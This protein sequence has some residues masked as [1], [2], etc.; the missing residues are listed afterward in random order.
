MIPQCSIIHPETVLSMIHEWGSASPQRGVLLTCLSRRHLYARLKALKALQTDND[1]TLTVGRSYWRQMED[2]LREARP[3]LLAVTEQYMAHC[4][5][6]D[7]NVHH[8]WRQYAEKPFEL[9]LRDL[10]HEVDVATWTMH[11][12]FYQL[13]GKHPSYLRQLAKMVQ[14]RTGSKELLEAF[15]I[16]RI[17][18][19]GYADIVRHVCCINGID[20]YDIAGFELFTEPAVD[21]G[22]IIGIQPG[23]MLTGHLKEASTLA[24][25]GVHDLE[26]RQLL[27]TGDSYWDF[28][29]MTE[30]GIGIL[31]VDPDRLSTPLVQVTLEHLKNEW[32]K[33]VHC[34]LFA[35][36]YHGFLELLYRA[37]TQQP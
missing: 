17:T 32:G 29:M 16:H 15:K 3:D 33:R 21:G 7:P 11:M 25:L 4:L 28:P 8:G 14:L 13:F 2:D 12:F 9:S 37:R 35:R 6:M 18:T 31:V 10:M 23:T 27:G 24:F 22:R 5:R 20:P 30:E 26:Q 34:V 1:E 36:D 19:S